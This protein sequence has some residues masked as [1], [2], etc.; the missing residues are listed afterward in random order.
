MDSKATDTIIEYTDAESNVVSRNIFSLYQK[1]RSSQFI[2]VEPGGNFGDELIYKGA[3]KLAR[4]AGIK[5]QSVSHDKFMN[6]D[7]PSDAVIYIHGGGDFNTWWSGNSIAEFF[8]TVSTHSGVI[9]L[10]PRTILTEKEFL[11]KTVVA[12]LRNSMSKKVYMFARELTSYAA[13]KAYLPGWVELGVDHDTALNLSATDLVSANPARRFVF[14]AIREDK[15]AINQERDLLAMWVDPT[16]YCFSFNQWVSLHNRAKE[17]VT[18]RLHSAILGPILGVPTTIIPNNYHKNRSVWE[19]SLQQQGV[20]WSGSVHVGRI[21]H[22]VNTIYPLR[23]ILGM[24]AFQTALRVFVYGA[25][26]R[27]LNHRCNSW[28]Y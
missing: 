10:G 25:R 21:A 23:K 8:K 6:S 3:R 28:L 11:R 2:F 16:R 20:R 13:L 22:I 26:R 1:Y 5:F 24:S 18:N 15:E 19:Y 9:I 12:G 14:Y 4:L 7:Y 27:N 17:I